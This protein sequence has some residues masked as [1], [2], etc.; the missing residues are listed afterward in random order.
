MKK[1]V[2]SLLVFIMAVIAFVQLI[3]VVML[4]NL[5]TDNTYV[6]STIDKQKL[7]KETESPRIIFTGGSNVA[8][9]INSDS[10]AE[11]SGYHV[12]NM[13][14]H[15]A[16]GID[17]IL[18][19]TASGIKKGDVVVLVPEYYLKNVSMRLLAMLS[20]VN[21]E[22]KNYIRF[23]PFDYIRFKM[24]HVQGFFTLLFY[25][26]E[27][28]NETYQRSGFSP[29][30]D[31]LTLSGREI[32]GSSYS[33]TDVIVDTN[34]TKELQSINSFISRVTGKGGRVFFSFPG[35]D[36]RFYEANRQVIANYNQMVQSKLNCT[37][38]GSPEDFVYEDHEV[39]DTNYHLLDPA[40]ARRTNKMISLLRQHLQ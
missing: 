18:N 10:V 30:G 26:G 39:F 17:Y 6:A 25:G 14:V 3:S 31:L 35:I 9:G 22:A 8:F 19:E 21:P 12:I 36:K 34:Y 16:F 38:L 1:F 15:A 2:I 27:I 28:F 40:K 5:I 29:K 23:T 20:A 7:L 37:I 33:Q 4:P 11:H 13:G 24:F 32:S